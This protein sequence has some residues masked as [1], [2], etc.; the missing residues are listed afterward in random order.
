MRAARLA[1]QS[2]SSP[3]QL[4]QLVKGERA[5]GGTGKGAAGQ[6]RSLVTVDMAH[7]VCCILRLIVSNSK[8]HTNPYSFARVGM[9]A[10]RVTEF[11]AMAD[12]L[13][14]DDDWIWTKVAAPPDRTL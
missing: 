6:G 4:C 8:L 11:G 5:A 9:N 14:G 12:V 1:L 2:C 3:Q 13:D 10:I 7:C